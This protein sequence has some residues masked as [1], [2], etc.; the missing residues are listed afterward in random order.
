[1]LLA[2]YAYGRK[3]IIIAYCSRIVFIIAIDCSCQVE[4]LFYVQE[5]QK[6]FLSLRQMG[7]QLV[8]KV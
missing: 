8:G 7:S 1:M 6:C 3:F 2:D 5:K 4:Y